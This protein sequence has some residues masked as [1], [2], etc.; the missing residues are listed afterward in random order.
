MK[1]YRRMFVRLRRAIFGKMLLVIASAGVQ[2]CEPK[3]F[4]IR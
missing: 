2:H 4:C 1:I 3:I